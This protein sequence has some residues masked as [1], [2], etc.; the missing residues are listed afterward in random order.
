MIIYKKNPQK[1]TPDELKIHKRILLIGCSGSGKSTFAR[2]L[3]DK[4]NREVIHLDR[5]FWKPGWVMRDRDEFSELIDSFISKDEWIIDGNYGRTL[6]ERVNRADLIFFFDYSPLFC[7]YR[8]LKRSFKT[9]FNLEERPDLTEEC[10]EKLFSKEFLDFIKYTWNFKKVNIPNNYRIIEEN[11]FNP[12][13]LI[14][15]R[16]HRQFNNFKKALV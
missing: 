13:K 6:P 2:F 4:L 8:V 16:N 1:I 10:D 9:R 15:F 5:H 12:E 3:G 14:I 11:N 7:T